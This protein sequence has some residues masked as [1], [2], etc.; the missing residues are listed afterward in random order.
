MNQVLNSYVIFIE[1]YPFVV[2]DEEHSFIYDNIVCPIH[3]IVM[4]YK[5]DD[6]PLSHVSY[7]VIS[8]DNNHDVDLFI[9]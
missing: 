1:N 3:Y 7:A 8:D 2:Q 5:T 4:D 6:G 9:K